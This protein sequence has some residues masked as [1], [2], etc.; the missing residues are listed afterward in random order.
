MENKTQK[1]KELF[2]KTG[3]AESERIELDNLDRARLIKKGTEVVVRNEHGTTFPLTDLS[4][5]EVEIFLYV[6]Q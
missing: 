2:L 4:D 6:L 3:D 5:Q 1:L